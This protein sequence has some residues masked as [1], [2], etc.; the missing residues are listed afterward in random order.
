MGRVRT[1]RTFRSHSRR[2]SDSDV[3]ILLFD[4]CPGGSDVDQF[5]TSACLIPLR[6][7]I[8]ARVIQNHSARQNLQ[9]VTLFLCLYSNPVRP[10]DGMMGRKCFRLVSNGR[11]KEANLNDQTNPQQGH[12][13]I[14]LRQ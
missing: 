7:G 2:T 1:T 12:L 3:A 13:P 8:G 11:A 14:M 9:T 6:I 10:S 4:C 5:L